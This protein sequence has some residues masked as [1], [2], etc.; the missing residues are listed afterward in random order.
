MTGE[1]RAA[2]EQR[3][4]DAKKEEAERQERSKERDRARQEEFAQHEAKML[5]PERVKAGHE[6]TLDLLQKKGFPVLERS[7]GKSFDDLMEEKMRK[8]GKSW[9][10]P[11]LAAVP[12]KEHAEDVS[13]IMR[14]VTVYVAKKLRHLQDDI[15]AV[16]AS[17]GGEFRRDYTSEKVTHV[18]F[19]GQ[20]ND[21]TKEF[22]QA[23]EDGKKIVA[24]D[25]VFM[26]RDERRVVEEDAFPHTFNPKMSLSLSVAGPATPLTRKDKVRQQQQLLAPPEDEEVETREPAR[27]SG[28]VSYCSKKSRTDTEEEHLELTADLA[29]LDELVEA[30]AAAS[31]DTPSASRSKMKMILTSTEATPDRKVVGGDGN[32]LA[33]GDPSQDLD[34]QVIQWRDPKEE[35]ERIKLKERLSMETQAMALVD[36]ASQAGQ[37]RS[38]SEA[39]KPF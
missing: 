17:L 22:R 11:A 2:M 8:V 21:R 36:D 32:T 16:V 14:G 5:A 24:P 1:E 26:C 34:S 10:N 3:A 12:N 7:G 13:Q 6:L 29:K 30:S 23:R 18:I 19:T 4:A 27:D 39:L 9:L 15:N 35:E 25:W 31:R 38:R 33:L 28:D 37:V 20:A